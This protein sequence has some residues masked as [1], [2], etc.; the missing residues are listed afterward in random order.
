MYA[1]DCALIISDKDAQ[2]LEVKVNDVLRLIDKW[3]GA[4]NLKMNLN[5]SSYMLI[6][7]SYLTKHLWSIKNDDK[8]KEIKEV[9]CQKFLGVTID[10]HINWNEHNVKLCS[11]LKSLTYLFKNL[12]KYCDTETLRTVYFSYFE[13]KIR[14]SI[15]SWGI[16]TKP[17][18]DSVLK[19]QKRF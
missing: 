12:V 7:K 17:N 18:I 15:S 4:N 2:N 11:F 6:K 5:K 19:C 1:D 13:S 16:T 14:F 10:E 8:F 3:F 9:R